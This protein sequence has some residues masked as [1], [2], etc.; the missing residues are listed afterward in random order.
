MPKKL[1]I[2]HIICPPLARSLCRSDESH[3]RSFSSL[4]AE[5][6]IN[7]S[8]PLSSQL[9]STNAVSLNTE[10]YQTLPRPSLIQNPKTPSVLLA[11]RSHPFF[12]TAIRSPFLPAARSSR[13][14]RTNAAERPMVSAK[15]GSSVLLLFSWVISVPRAPARYRRISCKDEDKMLGS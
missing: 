11:T 9:Q 15:R 3:R 10:K 14:I 13:C 4:G 5:V 12:P 8:P 1:G 6:P 7:P 2:A